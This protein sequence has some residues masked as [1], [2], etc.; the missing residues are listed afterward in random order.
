MTNWELQGSSDFISVKDGETS[1]RG[2]D[3]AFRDAPFK[4]ARTGTLS[5]APASSAAVVF[6]EQPSEWF[7]KDET[8]EETPEKEKQAPV[9]P[10]NRRVLQRSPVSPTPMFM[11]TE[12]KE[13]PSYSSS[14]LYSPPVA[15]LTTPRKVE[16]PRSAPPQGS[17]N[18]KQ[19]MRREHWSP[20]PSVR[21]KSSGVYMT[22]PA[23]KPQ[24]S[25]DS[26]NDGVV[27]M[28]MSLAEM[29][30]QQHMP[31]AQRWAYNGD[32]RSNSDREARSG[33]TSPR[34]HQHVPVV[35]GSHQHRD[36]IAALHEHE[37]SEP[38]DGKE[39]KSTRDFLRRGRGRQTYQRSEQDSV[40]TVRASTTSFQGSKG[41]GGAPLSKEDE[42]SALRLEKQQLLNQLRN[43]GASSNVDTNANASSNPDTKGEERMFELVKARGMCESYR[44][45]IKDLQTK[46]KCS[47]EATEEAE[48]KVSSLQRRAVAADGEV[49]DA[50]DL[51]VRRADEVKCERELRE[52]AEKQ[53]KAS[54]MG[55]AGEVEKQRRLGAELSMRMKEIG[56]LQRLVATLKSEQDSLIDALRQAEDDCFVMRSELASLRERADT[57]VPPPMQSPRH[58]VGSGRANWMPEYPTMSVSPS[59]NMDYHTAPP[60]PPAYKQLNK[61]HANYSE[62]ARAGLSWIADEPVDRNRPSWASQ[63]KNV[64]QSVD[65]FTNK[66]SRTTRGNLS[67]HVEEIEPGPWNTNGVNASSTTLADLVRKSNRNPVISNDGGVSKGGLDFGMISSATLER[68]LMLLSMETN[69]LEAE[70]SRLERGRTS[71]EIRVRII[72]IEDRLRELTRQTNRLKM[73]LRKRNL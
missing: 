60:P 65:S 5:V 47:L 9:R 43:A 26:R 41:L 15:R 20:S 42:V 38:I 23:A 37:L 18:E 51:A 45:E 10:R 8:W 64:S 30:L 7:T 72:D 73:E 69:Q 52:E 67:P 19:S 21:A 55:A 35:A 39:T 63:V 48:R 22:S 31:P 61:Y 44:T 25:F 14:G 50:K 17:S 6:Q 58:E 2:G 12:E 11:A 62:G 49:R 71:M 59:N 56:E 29:T 46:L 33:F 66:P 54:I 28:S 34:T 24:Q 4:A 32:S 40:P 70:K 57:V 1:V 53:A 36:V 68:Q 16:R 3:E 27:K 13:L